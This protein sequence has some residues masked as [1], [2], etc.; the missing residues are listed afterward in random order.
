MNKHKHY[1]MIMAWAAGETL[2][3]WSSTEMRWVQFTNKT[4][5]DWN[6]EP[7]QFRIKP[8]KELSEM[9]N[10]QAPFA[11]LLRIM[12]T[13]DLAT[14]HADN[15][16]DLIDSLESELRDVLGHYREA[17][18]AQPM[19]EPIDCR[20][21]F[22]VALHTDLPMQI[23][24]STSDG[25]HTFDELY[26]FRKAYNAALF[27]E[28]VLTDKYTVHKSK[29]HFDGEEC[30]GGGWFIV[31]AQLPEGL[32]SNHYELKDWDLFQLPETDKA[33]FEYDNHTAADVLHRLFSL[34]PLAQPEQEP[35]AWKYDWYGHKS[36]K[37]PRA[38]VKDWIASVY[39][40]VSDPTI[41]AHNI[42]P[43][44]AAPPKRAWVDL[45]NVECITIARAIEAK[46][47]EKNHG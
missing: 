1:E 43:L 6:F 32:I 21:A 47:K 25:Y 10:E 14:G 18:K 19:Q 33:L 24:G 34:R 41:N 38:L 40:E 42:R 31:A 3:F 23:T 13:F 37:E 20:E 7:M 8:D 30:F 22:L 36:E 17:L 29:R 45:T 2:E 26:D 9:T 46:L 35:I 27:N 15:I 12:G 39:T 5:I 4:S 11:R 16:N 28:W 44:Y